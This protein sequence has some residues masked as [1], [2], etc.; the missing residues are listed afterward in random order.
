MV[1][2]LLF[3]FLCTTSLAC[4]QITIDSVVTQQTSKILQEEL[5]KSSE[6]TNYSI[7][8]I[9]ADETPILNIPATHE[10][11]QFF[12]RFYFKQNDRNSVIQNEQ[13]VRSIVS[14]D[15]KNIFPKEIADSVMIARIGIEYESRNGDVRIVGALT[16][17][18][19]LV[20]GIPERGES[21]IFMYYDSCSNLKNIEI[22]WNT[23]KEIFIP[24][25]LSKQQ[26]MASQS[27]VLNKKISEL[28]ETLKKENIQGHLYKA[29]KSWHLKKDDKGIKYLV[30]SITY[31][32]T[33]VENKT[34]RYLSFDIDIHSPEKSNLSHTEI[35]ST[36]G[37]QK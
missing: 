14:M 26:N 30:P 23:H 35:C 10:K 22:K 2:A 3:F 37:L 24:E 6:S 31:L 13:D 16:K 8:E 9:S 20:D 11:T 17:L 29:I 28:G 19:R 1:K 4:A 15:I 34:N 5:V 21:Y 12:H 25:V 32:G 7:Y 36:K 18:H 27:I 33:Y